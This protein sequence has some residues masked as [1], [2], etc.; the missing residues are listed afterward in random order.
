MG[1][2][3]ESWEFKKTEENKGVI[4][5]RPPSKKAINL[6]VENLRDFSKV[7]ERIGMPAVKEKKDPFEEK[8]NQISDRK[9]RNLISA[10]YKAK[11]SAD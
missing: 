2:E 8:I 6:Y 7:L 4:E 9:L 5:V 3:L 11:I 1:Y 10:M